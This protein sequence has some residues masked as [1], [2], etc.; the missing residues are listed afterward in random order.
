MF[1]QRAE[2]QLS[3][4][5]HYPAQSPIRSPLSVQHPS[6]DFDDDDDFHMILSLTDSGSF[7]YHWKRR[8]SRNEIIERIYRIF[9]NLH[10]NSKILIEITK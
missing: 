1:S 10:N 5:N 6:D 7:G 3:L 2:P 9:G 8:D 4:P